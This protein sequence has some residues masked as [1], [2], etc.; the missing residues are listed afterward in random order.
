MKCKWGKYKSNNYY[1]LNMAILRKPWVGSEYSSQKHK[2]LFVGESHYSVNYLEDS[3][4]NEDLTIA[5]VKQYCNDE[6]KNR[7]W[8]I[9]VA[10]FCKIFGTERYARR[11]FF[12]KISYMNYIQHCMQYP[13]ESPFKYCIHNNDYQTHFYNVL[14][15]S[16][17]SVVILF[18]QRIAEL[19]DYKECGIANTLK[20]SGIQ[21][22]PIGHLSRMKQDGKIKIDAII[23]KLQ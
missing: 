8:G 19:W 17:P 10:Q 9:L 15:G 13:G 11:D 14:S 16:K 4:K 3:Q 1:Q 6:W 23:T 7:T 2:I 5:C 12:E 21:Y 18:S 20:E 22:F